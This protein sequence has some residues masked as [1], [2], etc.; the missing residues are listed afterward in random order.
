MVGGGG[1]SL[2]GWEFYI[3]W[4]L[5]KLIYFIRSDQS[6]PFQLI[7]NILKWLSLKSTLKQINSF[8]SCIL[9]NI[10]HSHECHYQVNINSFTD[11]WIIVLLKKVSSIHAMTKKKKKEKI[12][13]W[14]YRTT[15]SVN[16][17]SKWNTLCY[18]S[19]INF[20]FFIHFE[21]FSSLNFFSFCFVLS[22]RENGNISRPFFLSRTIEQK[23]NWLK[24]RAAILFVVI[25]KW[26]KSPNWFMKNPV[27][28]NG[29]LEKLF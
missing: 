16:R 8:K 23:K 11:C 9:Y 4:I 19:S 15:V 20:I 25:W 5:N 13:R 10:M 3:F 14:V 2:G 17:I 29:T 24:A 28:L 26:I 12:Q 7:W 6:I 1:G 22:S 21:K 18:L 27:P